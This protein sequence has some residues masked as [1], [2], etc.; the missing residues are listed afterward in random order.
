LDGLI[1][2]L[3]AIAVNG[4]LQLVSGED[5]RDFTKPGPLKLLDEDEEAGFI[6]SC[7]VRSK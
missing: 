6:L 4:G 2:S 7:G 1:C 3:K 5:A